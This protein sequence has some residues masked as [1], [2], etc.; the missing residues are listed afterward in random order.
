MARLLYVD[1]MPCSLCLMSAIEE[2]AVYLT[3]HDSL[4]IITQH[5]IF[6]NNPQRLHCKL[7]CNFTLGWSALLID[8]VSVTVAL[9]ASDNITL[10][11]KFSS[12]L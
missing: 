1:S 9:T 2:V 4:A 8:A 5:F 6:Q 3:S 7:G 12:D 11:L 10:L